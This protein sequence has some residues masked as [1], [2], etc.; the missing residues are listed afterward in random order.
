MRR[1]EFIVLFAAAVA[2]RPVI[3]LAQATERPLI[4]VIIGASQATSQGYR[5]AFTQHL[6]ELGYVEG[7][8]YEIEY[9]YAEG[10]LTRLP[11]LVDELIQ[12]KPSV[13]VVGNTPAAVAAKRATASI[14]II[15]ATTGGPVSVGL[16]ASEARPQ[17]NV[18][19]II[20]GLGSLVGKQLELGFELI[21]G[22]KR[23]GVLV[24]AGN[25]AGTV[26]RQGAEAAAQAMAAN[27]I[28]VEA[29][30]PA[31]IDSAFQTLA[32]ERVNIVIV[33][34][35]QRTTPTSRVV[36]CPERLAGG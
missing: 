16:A 24:N 27:L 20:S 22:A 34:P 30:T 9:R 15:A 18:T 19:G 32:R 12:R 31:D 7:R 33:V 10:D 6:Q 4:A 25:V 11:A 28:S 3:A 36:V 17:G 26:F 29:R 8:D 5:S 23:A 14:P 13:I 21:P 1:R 35:V 2:S